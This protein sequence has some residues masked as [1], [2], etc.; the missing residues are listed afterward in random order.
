MSTDN[1]KQWVAVNKMIIN[2]SK[3][4]VIVFQRVRVRVSDVIVFQ[5]SSLKHFLAPFAL[6]VTE[7]VTSVK[8]NLTF[9]EH[10]SAVLKC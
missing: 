10:V 8:N 5:R 3:T 4:K 9:D 6:S 7:Q 1:V 2:I